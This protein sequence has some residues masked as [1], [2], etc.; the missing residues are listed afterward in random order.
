MAMNARKGSALVKAFREQK[1][2]RK[3]QKKHWKLEGTKI[4]NIMGIQK[5]EEEMEDGPTKDAYKYAEHMDKDAP[6]VES[7]SDFVKKM[8]IAEQRRFLPVFAVREELMQVIRENSVVIIVG[9]LEKR[10]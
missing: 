9:K 6:E 8:T 4:G 1:E 10:E 3:A 7:K 5:K 2:R